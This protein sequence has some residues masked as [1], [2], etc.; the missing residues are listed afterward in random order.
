MPIGSFINLLGSTASNIAQA[1]QN[2]LNRQF[3]Q[4]ENQKDRD[5]N[6]EQAELQ[7]NWQEDIYQ[8]YESPAAQVQQRIA[9]G[10][11]P[12]EGVGSQ[13]V[14]QG[15]TA[16]SSSSP[17]PVGAPLDFSAF[18]QMAM[19]AEDLKSKKLD[20]Q[21]KEEQ[22]KREQIDTWLKQFEQGNAEELYSKE[23]AKL[24]NEIEKGGAEAESAK[25]QRDTLQLA[26]DEYKEARDSGINSRVDESRYK[27][28]IVSL[29]NA[30]S[31]LNEEQQNRVK[32]EIKLI[33]KQIRAQDLDN[34][35]KQIEAFWQQQFGFDLLNINLEYLKSRK[36]TEDQKR[37]ME[38]FGIMLDIWGKQI[39][40]Q[41]V[42]D[43]YNLRNAEN[44]RKWTELE[45]S[46]EYVITHLFKD[47]VDELRVGLGKEPRSW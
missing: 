18:S 9:A 11:N 23:L 33:N 21:A 3:Q 12:L 26:Y 10:L 2:R 30:L 36:L 46:A 16:H 14:G 31:S 1:E 20:N 15:S 27:T 8:K 25:I 7:R 13:S 39:Q 5:F 19:F 6:A 17:L 24:D 37:Q 28:S 38:I 44:L 4:A 42:D 41:S 45:N 35:I 40:E 29:N 22:V 47:V 43:E 34:S 32:S